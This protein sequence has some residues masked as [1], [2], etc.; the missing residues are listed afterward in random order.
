MMATVAQSDETRLIARVARLY[1]E[2]GLKQPEIARRLQLSQPKVSRLLKQ[3][4]DRDIVRITV[5]VPVGVHAQLEE[6]LESRYRLLEAV[7]VETSAIDEAQLMRDLGH[8]AAFHLETTIQPGDVIGISSW[9]ASLLA[10]VN[11]MHPVGGGDNVRVVQILGGVGNPAAEVHATQLTGR[12]AALLNGEQIPLPVPGVVGSSEAREVLERDEHVQR[13]LELFPDITVALVGIGT[14]QPSSLLA[15]SGNVFSDEELELVTRAGGVGDICL[16]F[17]DEHGRP[18][19]SPLDERVIGVT[20]DQLRQ[21]P[22]SIAV[23]GGERKVT[24]IKGALS[25]RLVSHLITDRATAER[26]LD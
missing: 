11:A 21:V 22:R 19:R 13:V 20:L 10:T 25:G 17:F 12:L 16:R 24:A 9:S 7:V 2:S 23:A 26:L 18:T 6:A 1:Y 4:V 14:V 3:A 15:R 8:A 5:R